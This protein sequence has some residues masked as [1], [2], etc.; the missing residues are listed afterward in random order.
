MPE[1]WGVDDLADC[2]GLTRTP[3][4][5]VSFADP[6]ADIGFE[7]GDAA[8]RRL[9]AMV[10]EYWLTEIGSSLTVW[11]HAIPKPNAG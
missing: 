6:F 7:F 1:P 3:R 11:H 2:L 9:R 8:A 10:T 4:V 5:G